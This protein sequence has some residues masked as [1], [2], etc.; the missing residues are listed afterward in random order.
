M[1][2]TRKNFVRKYLNVIIM[3]Y[4]QYIYMNI[5]GIRMEGIRTMA[6]SFK[7]RMV[8]DGPQFET[9]SIYLAVY[10]VYIYM[11]VCVW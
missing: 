5:L 6:I 8:P 3:Y 7:S 9:C 2:L 10:N 1:N 4:V 11:S